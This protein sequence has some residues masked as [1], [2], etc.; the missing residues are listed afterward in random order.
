MHHFFNEGVYL[1]QIAKLRGIFAPFPIMRDHKDIC[2]FSQSW[3]L[4]SLISDP[5]QQATRTIF[6]RKRDTFP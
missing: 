2:P 4:R 3:S 6:I 5:N 1:L